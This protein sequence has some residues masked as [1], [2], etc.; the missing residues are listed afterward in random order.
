MV[1]NHEG[2]L[3]WQG[4]DLVVYS[5]DLDITDVEAAGLFPLMVELDILV[6]IIG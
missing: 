3:C 2:W 4:A 5:D 1:R 6:H